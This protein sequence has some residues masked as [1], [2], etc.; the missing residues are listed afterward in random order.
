MTAGGPAGIGLRAVCA[1]AALAILLDP[2]GISAAEGAPPAGAASAREQSPLVG[3]SPAGDGRP[4]A[5]SATRPGAGAVP[6]K[7]GPSKESTGAPSAAVRVDIGKARIGDVIR[8]TASLQ[9]AAGVTA[10]GAP[11]LKVDGTLGS[12]RVLE[13]SS[14]GQDVTLSLSP[15]TTGDLDVPSFGV[16][17]RAADGKTGTVS[18]P[19]TRVGVRSVL[20]EGDAS[21]LADIK[22]PAEFPVPWPWKW[23]VGIVLAAAAL[24]I[25]GL[26]ISR[27]LGRSRAPARVPEIQLPPGI[28]PDIWARGELQKL[29]D[30]GLVASGLFREFHIELADIVRRYVELRYRIPALE[31]TT[32]EIAEELSVALL[33]EEVPGLV[34]GALVRCDAVKFAK[35]VPVGPE[36]DEAVRLVTDMLDRT[37]VPVAPAPGQGAPEPQEAPVGG[38]A[39]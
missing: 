7:G 34:T 33:A 2:V 19:S 1:G 17:Y 32:E 38:G 11:D 9:G 27:R 4:P 26:W 20:G 16:G 25:A 3:T 29:L 35:H 36:V 24:T 8:L 28:T 21:S 13:I 14:S 6:A 22:P 18:A 15:E 37:A 39:A 30:R 12:F 31:R 23:I 10:T 5:E